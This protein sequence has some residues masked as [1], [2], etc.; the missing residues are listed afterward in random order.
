MRALLS[1]CGIAVLVAC[2]GTKPD[3]PAPRPMVFIGS[4]DKAFHSAL[5]AADSMSWTIREHHQ[6]SGVIRAWVPGL[7]LEVTITVETTPYGTKVVK[8]TPET[9]EVGRLE[10]EFAVLVHRH[11]HRPERLW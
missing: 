10:P 2:A 3:E 9:P 11:F 7:D 6:E 1:L 4:F 8:L 5:A